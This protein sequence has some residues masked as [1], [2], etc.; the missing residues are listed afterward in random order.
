MPPNNNPMTPKPHHGFPCPACKEVFLYERAMERHHQAAHGDNEP[1][2]IAARLV[3][4]EQR[5]ADLEHMIRK[6]LS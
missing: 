5:V 1:S 4:L 3:D 6:M 2:S